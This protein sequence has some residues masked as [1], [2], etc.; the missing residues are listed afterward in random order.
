MSEEKNYSNP[1]DGMPPEAPAKPK[2]KWKKRILIV[3]AVLALGIFVMKS[4]D[5]VGQGEVG[6][7]YTMRNGV[8]DETLAP[9][10]HFIAPWATVKHYPVAQQQL[11]L[12]DEGVFG[13]GE[14]AGVILHGQRHEIHAH[15]EAA[16]E[17]G[18]EVG[19][20]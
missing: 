16:L 9:G 13:L 8:Q 5:R 11:V 14:D 2:N 15:G 19:G 17:L 1:T 3:V 7:V 4:L 6:V 20:L 12:P 10:Y 18:N